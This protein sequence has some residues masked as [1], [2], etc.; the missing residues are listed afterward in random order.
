MGV[1]SLN[2]K[3]FRQ[4]HGLHVTLPPGLTILIG[5]NTSGKSNV[6]EAIASLAAPVNEGEF[7][8]TVEL[9]KQAFHAQNG[10]L[11]GEGA[12]LKNSIGYLADST[13]L[14]APATIRGGAMSWQRIAELFASLRQE[15]ALYEVFR[16]TLTAFFPGLHI[17]DTAPFDGP[18]VSTGGEPTTVTT[19]GGGFQQIFSILVTVFSP[20]ISIVL[21]DEPETHLHPSAIVLLRTVLSDAA[22]RHNKQVVIST[23]SPL[24]LT[25]SLLSHTVHLV[26]RQT[27]Q[28]FTA[29]QARL[30]V[31]RLEQ[32]LTPDVGEA[33]FSDVVLMVEGVA[34]KLIMR[35]LW[36]RFGDRTLTMK[37][38]DVGGKGNFGI[39]RD[40]FAA[41]GIPYVTLV[42][43]DAL[44]FG[45]APLIDERLAHGR[46]QRSSAESKILFLQ[47]QRVFVLP[48]G[49]L[50][51]H[52]PR[53]FQSRDLSKPIAALHAGRG[54]TREEYEH[55]AQELKRVIEAVGAAAHRT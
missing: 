45:S 49:P 44:H 35:A 11:P 54:M 29:A 19:L 3:Y 52:F 4:V 28:A 7:T 17:S 27:T 37:I 53:R 34:D 40:L 31:E 30:N 18:L 48:H 32:E 21:I 2:I 51:A 25:P 33:F 55:E 50:E 5:K 8:L 36:D 13:V 14:D 16:K 24:F 26:R 22:L 41:F 12:T 10:R 42:D 9:N 23:H 6:L 43:R 47:T 38:V 1:R 20:Q 15:K 46:E 39:Y